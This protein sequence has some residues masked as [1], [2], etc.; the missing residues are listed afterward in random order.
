MCAAAVPFDDAG[1]DSEPCFRD[2]RSVRLP[3]EEP[4]EIVPPSADHVEAVFRLLARTV[5][6]AAACGSTGA[7]LPVV[8]SID[9]TPSATYDEP[10]RRVRRLRAATTKTRRRALWVELP[11]V[12][13]EAL[14]GE[15][16]A[17]A[18]TATPEGR[19]L[20]P[21][22]DRRPPPHGDLARLQRRL[23]CRCSGPHGLRHRR[24]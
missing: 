6:A 7:R 24:I 10:A 18:R 2:R 15:P 4:E 20:C 1:V 5:P 3:H 16:A 11:D 21:A 9:S 23:V 12:L 22:R 14:K 19:S 8:A 13:A 17:L